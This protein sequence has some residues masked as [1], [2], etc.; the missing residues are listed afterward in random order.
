MWV[1]DIRENQEWACEDFPH[2]FCIF[3]W[4][5]DKGKP[6]ENESMQVHSDRVQRGLAGRSQL[7]L[8]ERT[9]GHWQREPPPQSSQV[10]N[11]DVHRCEVLRSFRRGTLHSHQH[12]TIFYCEHWSRMRKLECCPSCSENL[13]DEGKRE[14]TGVLLQSNSMIR[15]AGFVV[16]PLRVLRK[17]RALITF[18][19]STPH[20]QPPHH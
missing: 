18:F 8:R 1:Y 17:Q 2:D 9:R 20:P 3:L 6:I 5:W 13:L 14:A 16:L 11:A 7:G 4:F 12:P 10:G 15:L 19:A